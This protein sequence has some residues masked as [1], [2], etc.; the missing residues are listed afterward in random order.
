M[1]DTALLLIDIQNM[2]FVGD[3]R[4]ENPEEASRNAGKLISTFR[5]KGLPV[6][7]VKHLINITKAKDI[8]L[9]EIHEFV[10]P[11]ENETVIGKTR[12][13]AFYA[14]NLQ[15]TLEALGVKN[16]V[17]AGMMS[18]MCVDTTVRAA[19][20]LGYTIMLADDACA[21]R[22]VT[23]RGIKIT[24]EISHYAFMAAL[25]ERF[26]TLMKTSEIVDKINE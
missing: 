26:A 6:I 14:T 12:P 24:A 19:F 22:A 9:A 13:S 23:Y 25:G 20:D 18:H 10:T 4:L 21:D 17:V 15:E 8:P 16:L 3:G 11:L 1:T 5:E 7:H 2:Y